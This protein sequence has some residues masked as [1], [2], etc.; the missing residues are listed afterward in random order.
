[1]GNEKDIINKIRREEIDIN[2]QSLFFSI[3]IK[4]LLQRLDDDIA[5]RGKKIPHIIINTGDDTMWLSVKG[6]DQSIEPIQVSNENYVYNIIPRCIANPGSIDIQSDQT[7]NPYCDG[8]LQ[9]QTETD[10]YSLIG[11]FRR[12]P[13]KLNFDL[14]YYV[15]SFTDMLELSQQIISKLCFVRTFKIMYM[16]QSINCSYTIPTTL[17]SEHM[18]E[19]D[20]RSEDNKSRTLELSLE[21]ET[22]YPVW[23][24][25]TI[26]SANAVVNRS[27]YTIQADKDTIIDGA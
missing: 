7:T 15:D 5:I 1:M 18:M 22:N 19:L 23:N 11:E 3:L 2:N 4:G 10:M 13:L 21:V 9:Y 27:R 26:L 8:E 6:Q 24:P 25:R 20:G 17:S 12:M 14:K 16:G